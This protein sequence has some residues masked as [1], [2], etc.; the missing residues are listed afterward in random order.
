MYALQVPGGLGEP[1]LPR[2]VRKLLSLLK[3]C[4]NALCPGGFLRNHVGEPVRWCGLRRFLLEVLAGFS[5]TL[6]KQMG[7]QEALVN[8]RAAALALETTAALGPSTTAFLMILKALLQ[9]PLLVLL[10][11]CG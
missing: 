11:V 5:Q 1:V 9:Q 7:S 2:L 6:F 8:T 3:E 10:G 4:L